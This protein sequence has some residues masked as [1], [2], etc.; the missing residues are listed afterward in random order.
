MAGKHA[1][2]IGTSV[3]RAPLPPSFRAL[4]TR[5]GEPSQPQSG[6]SQAGSDAVPRALHKDKG[7]GAQKCHLHARMWGAIVGRTAQT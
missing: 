3:K 7:R 6:G 1:T 2:I 4:L 5:R